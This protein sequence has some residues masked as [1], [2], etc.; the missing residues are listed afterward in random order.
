MDDIINI[1]LAAFVTIFSVGLLLVSMAS[2][3]KY[4]NTKLLF[5][6]LVFVL[7]FV[8]GILLTMNVF[9]YEIPWDW[10]VISSIFDVLVLAFLFVATLKR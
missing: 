5:V 6:S 9:G 3:K 4:K 1:I 8:K 7:F 10:I 2:Y